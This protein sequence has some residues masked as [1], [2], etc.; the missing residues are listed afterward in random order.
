[1][2]QFESILEVDPANIQCLGN[3]GNTLLALGELKQK[4]SEEIQPSDGKQKSKK[5]Y[6]QLRQEAAQFLTLAGRR[7][8]NLLENRPDDKRAYMN[9]CKALVTRAALVD[10][11]SFKMQLYEAAIAK[12]E[13]VFLW[14]FSKTNSEAF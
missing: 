10:D 7:F 9:W 1:M 8:K 2:E 3:C 4:M 5:A 14:L 11:P 13:Q 12:Y 6:D